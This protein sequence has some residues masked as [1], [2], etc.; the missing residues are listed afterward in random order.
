[1]ESAL[2]FSFKYQIHEHEKHN[3][4]KTKD[5]RWKSRLRKVYS[6][7]S[8]WDNHSRVYN[9]SMRLGYV[10]TL[11]AWLANP[12]VTGSTNPSDY[13]ALSHPEP[14][15]SVLF[16]RYGNGDII[17]I[18]PEEVAG[19]LA[20][21]CMSYEHVGQHGACDPRHV[22][23]HTSPAKPSEYR[24]LLKELRT[25]GYSVRVIKRLHRSF[26]Q[27]RLQQMYNT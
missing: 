3:N 7:F 24:D 20:R 17:A 9:L 13:G 10:S 14:K 21:F 12:L 4:M 15:L 1:L 18:F 11:N 26:L 5:R 16:R 23:A 8:D 22:V 19:E 25:I 27:M 6:S 2:A